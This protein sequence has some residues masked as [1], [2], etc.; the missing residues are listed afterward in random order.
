[1]RKVTC[2]ATS[3][4]IFQYDARYHRFHRCRS[5]RLGVREAVPNTLRIL[6]RKILIYRVYE[7]SVEFCILFANVNKTPMRVLECCL[8]TGRK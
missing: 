3:N 5:T 8:L 4:L 1:M 2:F 7:I 6:I